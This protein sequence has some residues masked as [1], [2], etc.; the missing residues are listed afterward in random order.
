MVRR[1]LEGEAYQR[2]SFTISRPAEGWEPA[3]DLSALNL[4]TEP[5]GDSRN[6]S[7]SFFVCLRSGHVKCSQDHM[8]RTPTGG[9]S[10]KLVVLTS[11]PQPNNRVELAC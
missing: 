8:A 9:T 5:G 10:L 6:G 3:L 4:L 1:D 11:T 7:Y 2:R